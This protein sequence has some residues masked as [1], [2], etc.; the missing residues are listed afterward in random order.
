MLLRSTLRDLLLATWKVPPGALAGK[1][2]A[3]LALE[4]TASGDALFSLVGTRAAGNRTGRLRAP[5]FSQLTLRTYVT[6]EN[7]PAVFFLGLRVTAGAL[8]A[9][10]LGMPVRAARIRIRDGLVAATAL[11]LEIAYRRLGP[12]VEVPV[13]PSGPLGHH[14]VAYL[15]S[16]G[17]R[18]LATTHEPF[19]WEAAELVKRPHLEPLLAL[20]L[21]VGQ[22]ASLLY[23]A[24]TRFDVQLP[25]T[26]TG[27]PV[28]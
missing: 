3:G 15:Y 14:D 10:A 6:G 17:V 22:P 21:D 5:D 24:S 18:R 12:A 13:L 23:A 2:P 19:V 26:R 11:G 4:T 7:G 27:G 8:G 1:L 28:Q 25:P 16:A 9:V 20:G